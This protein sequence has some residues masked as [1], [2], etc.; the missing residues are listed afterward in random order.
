[1]QTFCTVGDEC[2][3]R[4]RTMAMATLMLVS[5]VHALRP[6][7]LLAA[8]PRLKIIMSVGSKRQSGYLGCMV[9]FGTRN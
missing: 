5:F 4:L 1:M 6:N 8:L 3:V 7:F 2:Y 9:Y